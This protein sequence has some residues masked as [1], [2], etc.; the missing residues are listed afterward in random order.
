M[1]K[2]N[3]IEYGTFHFD[4]HTLF[5]IELLSSAVAVWKGDN[6]DLTSSGVLVPSSKAI[7][8]LN[9]IKLKVNK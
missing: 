1:N 8:T 5:L 3:K 2:Y 4:F 9:T 7:L 6:A